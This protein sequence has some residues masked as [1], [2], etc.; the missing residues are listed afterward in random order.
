MMTIGEK[1]KAARLEQL[2]TQKEMAK[3]LGVSVLSIV[4]WEN[5][6][7]VPTLSAQKKFRDFC[8]NKGIA[9][10]EVK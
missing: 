2:L 5:G 6:Q 7:N 8:H 10:D 4:R 1:I 3:E 9:F